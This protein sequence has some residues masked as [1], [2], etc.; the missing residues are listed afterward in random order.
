M[1]DLVPGIWNNVVTEILAKK[2]YA[3]VPYEPNIGQQQHI[4]GHTLI[5]KIAL[6]QMLKIEQEIKGKLKL[7]FSPKLVELLEP[8]GQHLH[9]IFILCKECHTNQP[10]L[11]YD[12]PYKHGYEWLYL[13][14]KELISEGIADV[15]Y[16]SEDSSTANRKKLSRNGEIKRHKLRELNDSCTMVANYENPFHET[17]GLHNLSSLLDAAI[18]LAESHNFFNNRYFQPY[19]KSW[20]KMLKAMESPEFKRHWVENGELYC[21]SGSGRGVRNLTQETQPRMP[22]RRTGFSDN[23]QLF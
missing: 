11:G 1:T 22:L 10:T 16:P 2:Y 21:Q 7:P 4:N 20:R 3:F 19:I 13:I 9:R 6:I 23:Q 5:W 17:P 18:F 15:L 12:L 8:H 14:Y